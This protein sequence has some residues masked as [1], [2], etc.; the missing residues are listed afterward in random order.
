VA[1]SGA[2]AAGAGG[3]QWSRGGGAM[4]VSWWTGYYGPEINSDNFDLL[5]QFQ[6]NSN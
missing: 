1:G 4:A 3:N 5:K 6:I 2:E